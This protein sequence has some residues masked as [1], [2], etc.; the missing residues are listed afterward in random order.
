LENDNMS[1]QALSHPPLVVIANSQ[2]WHTRS[3]ESILG[4]HGYAVLRAYTGRQAIERVLSAQPDIIIVDTDLPDID[5]LEVCRT[6]RADT[7]ISS[8]TPIL[9]T[10][11]GHPSRQ[12]RLAALRAGAWEFL[13]ATLDA[14]ELPL[15]LDAYVRAKFD[16]DRAREESLLDQITGLYNIR[17][18]ARRAR[19]LGSQAFRHH[20]PFAC[21][22]FAP[23]VDGAEGQEGELTA[24]VDRLAKAL[25]DTG[26][27]S[28]AIGRLGPTEF[29]VVAQGTDRQG[30]VRLAE[31]LQLALAATNDEAGP[32]FRMC[33]GYDAVDNYHDAP[34]EPSDMLVRATMA[35]RLS[36]S[37]AAGGWIR[38]FESHTVN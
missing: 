2:E 14:E 27:V 5:G 24:A 17:G 7:R 36:R 23:L 19:E 12:K 33:A 28:D 4:P 29:A 20:E 13:G 37:D 34:I 26:R 6:L 1:E 18:I 3:L 8:S 21:V 35:M 32:G 38:A 9:V 25:R 10:S 22:V 31:R 11:P 15:R 16:A 30:A